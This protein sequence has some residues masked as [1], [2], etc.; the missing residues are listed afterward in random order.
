[1]A[2]ER[3]KWTIS[4]VIA[5]TELS[6]STIRRY[7]AAGKF[8][9]AK[10]DEKTKTWL[11]PVDDLLAAQVPMKKTVSSP[12]VNMSSEQGEQRQKSVTM[13][14]EHE[15]LN[16]P[17]H[18]LNIANKRISELEKKLAVEEAINE[19]LRGQIEILEKSLERSEKH[20]TIFQ[21]MLTQN[22]SDHG[23]TKE[24]LGEQVNDHSKNSQMNTPE[25]L[26]EHPVEQPKKKS[27]WRR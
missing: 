9:N 5:N 27:W 14:S 12:K 23:D 17:E 13:S 24:H 20:A 25:Q 16:T 1:M 4:E 18:P 6:A 22:P 3:P 11:Y 2:S 10:Q 19:G 15:Q 8:P 7:R 21:R 26:P